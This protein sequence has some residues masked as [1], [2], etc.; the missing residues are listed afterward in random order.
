MLP[1]S[2]SDAVI[3]AATPDDDDAI[4]RIVAEGD[5]V[6]DAQYLALVR[7]QGVR[8]S[9]AVADGRV[10]GF[11]GAADLVEATMLT[12]LFV[13]AERRGEGHG[14]RLLDAVFAERPRRMTFSS[15]HPAA[16]AAYARLGMEAR[17]R[18]LYLSGVATGGGSLPPAA[19]WRHD[20]ASLVEQWGRTGAHVSSDIVLVPDGGGR[21]IA[22]LQHAEPVHLVEAVVAGLPAGTR[23]TMCVPEVSVLAAWAP[24][25]DFSVTAFDTFRATAGVVLAPDLHVLD[26]GLA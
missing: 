19:A 9:V 12:D 3:R 16:H 17:W 26:P 25:H 23:V 5:A 18:L 6:A 15:A 22:R 21:R 8:L 11:A 1:N 4:G 20:R 13:A 14:T 10:V 7:A 24:A 2:P